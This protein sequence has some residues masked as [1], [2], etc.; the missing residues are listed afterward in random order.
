MKYIVTLN[1]KDYEVE[2]DELNEAIVT[3][4]APAS[5]MPVAPVATAAPTVAASSAAPA[6][7]AVTV[8]GG[9]DV[10]AP[11]PGT[12]LSVNVTAGQD[13]KTGDVLFVLEAMKMENEIVAP[14]DG[15]ISAVLTSKGSTVA[16]DA[17]LASIGG[18]AVTAPV[19][20]PAPVA[21]PA[22]VAAPAP[23][24]AAAPAPV[25]GTGTPV[26]AP[27]PGTILSVNIAEGQAVSEG[28]VLFVL[29][30]MKME[31]EIVA[32]VSGTVTKVATAKGNTVAT[33]AVL[34]FIG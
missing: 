18:S 19:P 15:K 34:A 12:I 16:T 17:V 2:V 7:S 21:S 20:T 30:A 27:M 32:P 6:A 33:D 11:M 13:V 31:N 10:K 24:P 14:C 9:T 5:A 28:D 1:G 26:N 29:E 3:N 25:N 23:A 8:S 4:I 22:P